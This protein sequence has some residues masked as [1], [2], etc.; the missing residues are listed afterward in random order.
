MPIRTRHYGLEAHSHGDYYSASAD[1][2]RFK[3]IDSQLG[4]ISDV[5]GPGIIT[6][7][8]IEVVEPIA[9]FTFKVT[10]GMGI[11]GRTVFLSYGDMGFTMLSNQTKYVYMKKKT[12]E[13]GGFSSPSNIDFVVAVDT[14]S[15]SIPANLVEISGLTSFDQIA[16]EW[17]ANTEVDFSHYIVTRVADP[18]YGVDNVITETTDTSFIDIGLEQNAFYTYQVTAVDFSGNESSPS[19]IT[20]STDV[21][22]RLP[23]PPLFLQ[24]FIGNE[25]AQVIWDHSPS[26]Y[27]EFYE[28]QIQLLDN[29][30][31]ADGSPVTLPLIDATSEE[32]FGSTYV[33]VDDLTNNRYYNISVR[34]L[35]IGGEYSQEIFK[36]VKPLYNPGAGEVKNIVAGFPESVFENVIMETDLEWTHTLD[37]Y[38]PSPDQFLITFLE[39]G[40][41]E[42]EPISVLPSASLTSC[43]TPE[44]D[45]LCYAHHIQFIPYLDPTD[46]VV[47]FESIKEYTPYLII[48][49]TYIEDGDISSNGSFLRVLR[50]PAYQLL[51]AVSD[52]SIERDPNDNSIICKWINPADA[53]FNN[54]RVTAVITDLNAVVDEDTIVADDIDVGKA[55]SYAIPGSLF[56]VDQRYTFT[57]TPVDIFDR[58]G[59]FLTI[60]DQ[61]VEDE[62]DPRPDSPDSIDISSHS[63]TVTMTW[64]PDD[65]EEVVSYKIYKASSNKTF[66]SA[67][68]FA[69]VAT[70]DSSVSRFTDYNVDN[71]T[72]YAYMI[73]SFNIYG[74]E[75][76]NP[77]E[78]SYVTPSLLRGHPT[79]NGVLL[80]PLNMEVT[81]VGQN[82]ELDWEFTLGAFDG[83]E[84]YRSIGNNYTFEFI[85]QASPASISYTDENVLLKDGESYYYLVRKYKN[86]TII[87]VSDSQVTPSES[88]LLGSVTTYSASEEPY[89]NTDMATVI[90]DLQTPLETLTQTAIDAHHHDIDEVGNDKR[91]E[92]RANSV[93]TNWTTTDFQLYTT[94]TDISGAENYIIKVLA[95]VNEAY[96]TSPSGI[97]NHASI[98]QAQSGSPPILYTID[99]ENGTI[100]FDT[101]LF[102]LCVEPENPDPLDP[103]NI[104]PVTPY[105]SEPA[106]SLELLGI[107]E[108]DNEITNEQIV[109]V[110]GTQITSGVF[111]ALQIPGIKHDGRIRESL[112]PLR[113][114]TQSFDN[115]VYSLSDVYIDDSRN[116]MGTAVTFYDIID[117]VTE[118]DGE[119]ESE[120]DILAATSSGIWFSPDWGNTWNKKETFPE[121]VHRVFQASDRKTYAMTNYDVFLSDGTSFTSWLQMAGLAGVKA[122]RDV[123]EDSTGNI[124]I[125]TDLG[126]FRLNKDKPYI[127]DTWEQLSIFGVKS[128]EA[129]G[130]IYIP[131]EDKL[132]TSNELGILEST[133]EGA[134]WT[135]ISEL[136]ITIKVIRFLREGNY[137]FA[138]TNDKLYRKEIGVVGFIEVSSIGVEI[139]RQITIYNDKIYITTDDGI[140]V[141]VSSDIYTDTDIEFL[142]LWANINDKGVNT[143]I[144]SLN[145]LGTTMFVGRDRKLYVFDGEKLWLQYEQQNT[146]VPTVVVNGVEQKLG[147]YYNNDGEFHNVSFYEQVEYEDV[148]TISN[149]YNIYVSA[150]GGWVEQKFDAKVKVWKNRLF[151][152]ESTGDIT[153]DQNPF[154][155][156]EFPVYDDSN[157]NEETALE[158]QALMQD[159]LDIL[160][161][162]VLPEGDDLTA[163]ISDTHSN[164]QKFISQLYNDARVVTT[165]N[166]DGTTSTEA[167]VFPEIEIE[168]VT[169]SPIF[170]VTGDI[171][172]EETSVGGF[173]DVSNGKFEFETDFEK[174]DSFEI[175]VIGGTIANAGDLTHRELEDSLELVNSGLPSVLSQVSQV[176]NVKLGIFVETKWPEQRDECSPPFQAEYIIPDSGEWYDTLN[177][178]INYEEEISVD[179]ITFAILY[180]TSVL[181]IP[182][183]NTI[184]VGGRGGV[185]NIKVDTLEMI[186]VEGL[187]IAEENVRTIE[188]WGDIL[189]ILT[190]RKI[191]NSED[192]GITWEE[193]DSAGLPN[194][195]GTISFIQNNIIIGAEDGIYFRASEF[196]N[197]EKVLPSENMVS[198]LSNPD[199]LF[200]VVDN[201]IYISANGYSYV[202]LGVTATG[203][204]TQL[205]KHISTI[206][207]ST[208]E[209]LFNDTGTF[210]G[211]SPVLIQVTLDGKEDE[212]VND[213]D[214]DQTDLMIGMD[215]GSYFQLNTEGTILN[216]FSDL[217]A[218]HQILL[219]DSE[220]YLFGFN[221]MKDPNLDFPI[222][223]TTGV[224]L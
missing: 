96:Y 190:D 193:V 104:C 160:T 99:A 125:T 133:N 85:G 50:T 17:D 83:Y 219:I 203:N 102:T 21:D 74:N 146:I 38:L 131:E 7:W 177:S 92:L 168:L 116:L 209:G 46:G 39:N 222:R 6:G 150:S 170:T 51:P 118:V 124:F 26:N 27:V 53:F 197:W 3:T 188:R 113:V 1:Q 16:F 77:V 186:E 176:N 87:F 166:A 179:D 130:I 55:T 195:L 66:Y 59:Q 217:N 94:S 47:K 68:D 72:V 141:S 148:V 69:H 103:T 4:L 19:E 140:K 54:C 98:R 9:D 204:I 187:D 218:I 86:E 220:V 175:D 84:V 127:E 171:D 14:T 5:I 153:I 64:G 185:L 123:T 158:Y 89:V 215:D 202:D 165:D 76:L 109:D 180:P 115:F 120:E 119:L 107:S 169:L 18:E 80:P 110:N 101:P 139:S 137:I 41:R 71:G 154:I 126:V 192:F 29:G 31:N 122:I 57:I 138:L 36:I 136:D 112:L 135:F 221:K 132:F 114:P 56:D 82:V 191:Y 75:S 34:S 105:F 224:P 12:D 174:G 24:V 106:I 2:R 32:E 90:K 155:L 62:L 81:A 214:T 194:N 8:D 91:I 79:I 157:A 25:S 49:R 43:D 93:V 73:T 48:I 65:T 149:R 207:V 216:E 167:L 162:L 30:Y 147:Y 33:F 67:G 45:K 152:A 161:V 23:L 15:P 108:I 164:Y 52:A 200:S 184:L 198:I 178:T 156:F 223:L 213:L 205:V 201:R 142:A 134:T 111:D 199:V 95:E 212:G 172:F 144:T 37:E 60:A 61:F 159:D 145:L 208:D 28:V 189:Y 44:L 63:G 163:L 206:Y 183:T 211:D 121:T 143:V 128:T 10:P 196:S 42:S 22:I 100:T 78:D 13:T 182:E 35:S 97:Q 40:V 70:V 151:Y 210:Y 181:Y 58:D 88:V 20:I 11:I 173:Y 129:Y 117:V